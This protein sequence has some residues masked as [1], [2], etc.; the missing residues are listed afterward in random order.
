[1]WPSTSAFCFFF[2]LSGGAPAVRKEVIRNKIRAIGKMARVFSVLRLVF[3]FLSP[4][5]SP[6]ESLAEFPSEIKRPWYHQSCWGRC[7][8]GGLKLQGFFPPPRRHTVERKARVTLSIDTFLE[9]GCRT[10]RD[11]LDGFPTF[12]GL[13]PLQFK[14]NGFFSSFHMRP[15]LIPPK[16]VIAFCVLFFLFHNERACR[17]N[18]FELFSVSAKVTV[19]RVH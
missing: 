17:E 10:E 5:L 16:Y 14:A 9:R 15:L 4:H 8:G 2:C 1:M 6:L 19:S 7:G 12:P 13:A 3:S 11:A 18:V